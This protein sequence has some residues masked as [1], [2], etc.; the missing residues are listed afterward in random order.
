M[1]PTSRQLRQQV[2][3]L[4]SD[5]RGRPYR[6][7]RNKKLTLLPRFLAR[8]TPTSPMERSNY[9]VEV[10]E[11]N[12]NLTDILYR[13]NSLCEKK[14]SSP[15][16][17][18]ILIRRERQT[19]RRLPRTGAIVFGVKT[20]LTPLDE[21]PMAELDNL[22]KEMKS[23]PDYVGEYKGRDVWGAKVLEYYRKRV[24]GEKTGN[25]Q[26]SEKGEVCTI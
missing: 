22:A 3:N 25:N 20:Y 26:E 4:K 17:S 13:P 15:S 21:L 18:D 19:F 16:P 14:L 9:F 7:T 24:E 2:S 8:L 23:W 5:Q 10:K 12:E 6:E 1:A 11:P